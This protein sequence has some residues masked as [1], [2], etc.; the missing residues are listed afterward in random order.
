MQ[1]T[2]TPFLCL[3]Y[4]AP[5]VKMRGYIRKGLLVS[6]FCY[7]ECSAVQTSQQIIILSMKLPTDFFIVIFYYLFIS[8]VLFLNILIFD[9]P[10]W[11]F[12]KFYEEVTNWS[13]YRSSDQRK[14][15]NNNWIF[16]FL[17]ILHFMYLSVVPSGV[18]FQNQFINRSII[19]ICSLHSVVTPDFFPHF[20][21]FLR[22]RRF[23]RYNHRFFCPSLSLS[24]LFFHISHIT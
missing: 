1:I 16:V 8:S 3:V 18:K 9:Y 14:S 13:T 4:G 7:L 6:K 2:I 22:T 5:F 10:T 17:F 24:L 23:L 15:A 11:G 12:F 19:I 21:S 20:L